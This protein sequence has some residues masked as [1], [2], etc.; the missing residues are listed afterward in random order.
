MI[1]YPAA[2]AVAL[3][4]QTGS[5]EKAAGLLNVS[6]SA[7]SQRVRQLEERLGTALIVRGSPCVA[8][9]KGAWLCRHMAQ[10]G[11]LEQALALRLPELAAAEAPAQRV[12]LDVAT[13][14]DSLGA[15]FLKAAAAFAQES[16]HLLNLA[17]DD[18]EHTAEWLKRGRVLA[19][20]VAQEKPVPG[21]RVAP[22]G[23]MRYHA[24]A[25]PA[26]MARHFPQGV[27]P[28]ALA[29][30]PSLVFNHKDRLQTDWV[31]RVFGRDVAFPAHGIPATQGFVE[32]CLF[33]MGWGLNPAQL[34]REHLAAGRLVEVIPGAVLDTPLFWQTSRLAADQIAALTRIV[35]ETAR[36]ELVA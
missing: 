33:G 6:P 7:V 14:A 32:A 1:D 28:E 8:T 18:Q 12:T 19:A 11:M 27:T 34:V 29:R 30:A 17:V 31:R 5:F 13:N 2:R 23:A 21:C 25:S 24:T 15:W 36:R 4:A 16:D 9:E 3:I 22:L 10:V 26:Y 20:V 35:T